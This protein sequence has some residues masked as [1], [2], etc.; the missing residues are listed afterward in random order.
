ML[1]Q[2][3]NPVYPTIQAWIDNEAMP[4]DITSP[5][6]LNTS[7]DQLIRSLGDAVELLGFGEALHAWN[8][9]EAI[10]QFRNQLFQRLVEQH[11]YSAIAIESSFPQSRVV[12]DFITGRS[13][14]SCEAILNEGFSH[15]FGQLKANRELIEWMQE[16]N[17]DHPNKV[18]FYGFDAP[19][20]MAADSPRKLLYFV[21]DYL[22]SI[23]PVAAAKHHEQIDP[24][25][26]EDALWEN[27]EA[28]MNPSLA[29]GLSPNATALRI[30]TENLISG[31]HVRQPELIAKRSMEDFIEAVH[32]A[33]EAR[34]LLNYHAVLAEPSS[35]RQARLL[36]IRDAMMADNVSYITSRERTH[37]KVLVFAHN[38]HL[39]RSKVEWQ[40][41]DEQVHWWPVGAHLDALFGS[42]YKVIASAVGASLENE[43]GEPEA[44]TL[45]ALLTN[46]ESPATLIP[47]HRGN[48]ILSEAL[49]ALPLRSGSKKNWS[50]SALSS[51]SI[52]DFDWL[53]TFGSL[54]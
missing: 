50:Y 52:K 5:N 15:R 1:E 10:L 12:N 38:T 31:L 27:P 8:G 34:Q 19:T 26:G 46:T 22:A 44:D 9:G 35:D 7:I 24:L 2:K 45:E 25:L 4:I 49:H 30:A 29:I 3:L 16:Y 43:I 32:Y 42:R 48:G 33:S 13:S 53:A 37:G 6:V 17:A 11:G 28:A 14:V 39:Q 36:N 51:Q 20:D 47:T 21:L 41:G 18:H 23:D 40:F 54:I